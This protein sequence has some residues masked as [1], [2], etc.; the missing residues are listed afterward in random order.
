M[1]SLMSIQRSKLI[2]LLGSAGIALAAV[3]LTVTP[4]F[5]ADVLPPKKAPEK[6]PDTRPDTVPRAPE[7]PPPPSSIDPGIERR[8]QTVPHP[9]SA[10]PPPNVDPDIAVNPETAPPAAEA[11][12]PK[13][14]TEPERSTR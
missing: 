12:K 1:W 3:C 8:P 11:V 7:P 13:G 4:L 9:R 5:A 2:N 10:V 6:A 14:N